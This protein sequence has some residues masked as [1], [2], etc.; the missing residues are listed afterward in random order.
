MTGCRGVGGKR[1]DFGDSSDIDDHIVGHIFM[2]MVCWK[3]HTSFRFVVLDYNDWLLW[4]TVV[5]LDGVALFRQLL[6]QGSACTGE[7]ES[8]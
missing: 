4:L 1:G 6:F 5:N 2:R 3:P 7:F 8:C